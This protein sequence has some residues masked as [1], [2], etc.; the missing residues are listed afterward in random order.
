MK[1]RAKLNDNRLAIYRCPEQ[2]EQARKMV[3]GGL[4]ELKPYETFN[5]AIQR[6]FIELGGLYV[7]QLPEQER[8]RYK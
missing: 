3:F 8:S 4:V 7:R 2:W 6:V 5:D 1:R